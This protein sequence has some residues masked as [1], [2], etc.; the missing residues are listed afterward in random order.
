MYIN[1][2]FCYFFNAKKIKEFD[3]NKPQKYFEE[4]KTQHQELL[5]LSYL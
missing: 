2:G 4:I 3:K 1:K 5:L